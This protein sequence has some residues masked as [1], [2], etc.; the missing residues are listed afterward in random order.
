MSENQFTGQIAFD[1]IET[2]DG[3][4]TALECNPRATSGVHLLAS[5]PRFAESFFNPFMD[6][7]TPVDDS[8]FMLSAAMLLYGLPAALKNGSLKDWRKAYFFSNDVIL[9]FND[10]LPFILQW[11]SVLATRAIAKREKL[12]LLEAS[13]FDIEWNGEG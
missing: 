1:F 6:C 10:P 11:R 12:S 5:H 13:T 4:V 7:I 9:D 8:S 2:P 3:Q